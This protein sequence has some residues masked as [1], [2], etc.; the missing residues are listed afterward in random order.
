VLLASCQPAEPEIIVVEVTSTPAVEAEPEPTNVPTEAPEARVRPADGMVMVPVPAGEFTMGNDDAL[1]ERLLEM[2]NEANWEGCV[3]GLFQTALPAH[4]VAL[5]TYWIDQT[6]VT[7]AQ[8][9]AFLNEAGNQTEGGA[10]WWDGEAGI[11]VVEEAGGELSYQAR[12]GSADHPVTDV[13]WYG[14]AAY[15]AWAGARLPT[16][17]EWEYAAR[18]PESRV[19]PW[20]DAF[21]GS[22]LNYC[23]SYCDRYHAD[24]ASDDGYAETA[25]VGSYPEGA[26]WC[27]ALD[28]A[29][30]VWE[31]TADW[32]AEDYYGRSP[33]ANPT[34][35]ASGEKRVARSGSWGY[36][37]SF[38]AAVYRGAT[39]P[40]NTHVDLGF[41]C[42]ASGA[43][44][45]AT[46][47]PAAEEPTA[48]PTAVP[49]AAPT[50]EPTPDVEAYLRDLAAIAEEHE[51]IGREVVELFMGGGVEV[52]GNFAPDDED[53]RDSVAGG[54]DEL[55]ALGEILREMEP[56]E[57]YAADHAQL[58]EHVTALEGA[59]ELLETGLEEYDAGDYESANVSVSVGLLGVGRAAEQI[60]AQIEAMTQ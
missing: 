57:E 15:C 24:E 34:G 23:D 50:A 29:G 59:A 37:S 7:N 4:R 48:M 27:G 60:W 8:F 38:T 41:R 11:A 42:A 26:S 20:G 36:P 44:P 18:G 51:R 45:L 12:R 2:C 25:P 5:E 47:T 19:F 58:L 55:R 1:V 52:G 17:A 54:L 16:E 40:A 10:P 49:T 30:N 43:P 31:W 3:P 28:M 46:A 39:H 21:D 53:W 14:A 35:P 13:T 9:A 6:E 22:R 33:D 32:Y 56:P